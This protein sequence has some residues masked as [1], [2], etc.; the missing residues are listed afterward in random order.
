MIIR[1]I[2]VLILSFSLIQSTALSIDYEY[3]IKLK[4]MT[5][6]WK[7]NGKKLYVQM[8]GATKGWVGIGFNPSLKM[9]DANFV[10]GYVKNGTVKVTDAFGVRPKE[11]IDDT[12]TNGINNISNVSGSEKGKSTTIEFAIPMKSEDVADG[13]LSSEGFTTVLLAFGKGRD[14]FTG[15]HRYRTKLMV[16]LGTGQYQ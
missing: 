15:R 14:N 9:Q 11:H 7:I 12:A 10:L 13:K 1:V 4:K 5:F 8:T 16:N 2:V 6:A 3:V